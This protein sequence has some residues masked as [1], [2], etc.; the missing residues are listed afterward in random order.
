MACTMLLY[1]NLALIDVS[2]WPAQM[3]KA[4]LGLCAVCVL[5]AKQARLDTFHHG[6]GSA[7]FPGTQAVTLPLLQVLH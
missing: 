4:G 3:A 6:I 2:A 1:L 7:A 5:A